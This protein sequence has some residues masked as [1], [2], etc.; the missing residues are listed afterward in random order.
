MSAPVLIVLLL[1]ATYG[2]A[3]PRRGPESRPARRASASSPAGGEVDEGATAERG[4]LP[5]R[6]GAAGLR[7]EVALGDA[8]YARFDNGAALGHYARA[9]EAD[10]GD[11]EALWRLALAH[12]DVGRA[13]EEAD[14]DEAE[15]HYRRGG[16]AARRAI[17]ASPDSANAHFVL[18]VCL[19]RLAL[20]EG[21]KIR[22]RLSREV[23]KEAERAI[24]LDPGHDGAYSVLG[25]W[26][27]AVATLGWLS[28]AFARVVYGGVPPGASVERAAEMFRKAVELDPTRPAHRLEYAR[29]LVALGR[30]AEARRQ[31]ERCLALPRVQWDDPAS[32]A[33]AARILRDIAGKDDDS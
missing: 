15:G 7:G 33:E 27:Y 23:K 10:P 29:A 21:G 12:T 9:V 1:V 2:D 16:E 28:R 11:G 17:A 4:P 25:R 19:G 32:K 24:E 6:S 3:G 18:A 8:A 26:N 13:L 14:P 31:L 20:L 30:Y 22:I 5:P